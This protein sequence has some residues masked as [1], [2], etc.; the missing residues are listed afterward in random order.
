MRWLCGVVKGELQEMKNKVETAAKK[1]LKGLEEELSKDLE[2]VLAKDV[3]S[4]DVED[5]RRRVVQLVLELKDRHR[6]EAL[7]IHE[8]TKLQTEELLEKYEELLRK[9]GDTYEALIA[10]ECDK[11][12]ATEA[13][14][15]RA[16]KDAELAAAEVQWKKRT[17]NELEEQRRSLHAQMDRFIQKEKDKGEKHAGKPT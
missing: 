3:A 1:K 14:R 9:Q 7:R 2:I 17:Q 4:G 5:L 11:A 8:L 13:E 10:S 16:Q 6:W 12:A 15:V